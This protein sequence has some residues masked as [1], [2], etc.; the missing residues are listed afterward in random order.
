VYSSLQQTL[1]YLLL[2]LLSENL[3]KLIRTDNDLAKREGS[4]PMKVAWKKLYSRLRSH[5]NSVLRRTCYS[6]WNELLQS[7]K[8][9][10]YPVIYKKHS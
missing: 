3:T 6:K 8:G 1:H 10:E 5:E 2:V 7:L 4:S 9:M